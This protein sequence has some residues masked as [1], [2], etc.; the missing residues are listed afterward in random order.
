MAIKVRVFDKEK[1]EYVK[2]AFKLSFYPDTHWSRCATCGLSIG[3][4]ENNSVYIVELWSTL[5]DDEKT[6]LYAGDVVEI[7]L[8]S[9]QI[10]KAEIKFIDGCFEVQA[11]DFCFPRPGIKSTRDYLKCYTVN[12]AV[13]KIGNIHQNPELVEAP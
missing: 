3:V 7:R 2:E 9:G 8:A 6:D 11:K 13:K 4:R 1:N 10:I 12:H 5:Q